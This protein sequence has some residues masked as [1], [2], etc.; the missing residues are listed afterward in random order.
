MIVIHKGKQY[1]EYI[2]KKEEDF[3]KEVIQNH[4]KLFNEHSIFIDSK[5]KIS[6]GSLGSSIP[7]GFL[8]DMSDPSNREF[9]IVEFELQKHD[10]YRH[11][12]PQ[13]TKFFAFFKSPQRQKELVEK[14]FSV[15]ESD[16]ILEKQF[17][18]YLGRVEI[19]KFISDVIKS[20]QNILLAID[21]EKSEL[22]EITSTYLETWGEM[23]KPMVIKKFVQGS[24]HLYTVHPEFESIDFSIPEEEP[25]AEEMAGVYTEEFHINVVSEQVKN[26]YRAIKKRLLTKKS[27]FV[28]NSQKYYISIKAPKNIAFLKFRKSKIR[29]V[30]LMS[31]HQLRRRIKKHSIRRLSEGVQGFYNG[32]CAAVDIA[33]TKNLDEII[34]VLREIAEGC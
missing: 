11:I 31:E 8:F 2:F 28:L 25:D 5:K 13:I 1:Q 21:G 10:F 6:S 7:D 20:S 22:R 3:E 18:S 32:P 33:D 23:V 17:K 24:Q 29:M 19:Y 27:P 15:I 9:Y 14:L 26:A 34:R 30:I 4:K 16:A 12:F